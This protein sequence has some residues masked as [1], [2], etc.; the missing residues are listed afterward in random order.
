MKNNFLLLLIFGFLA[1]YI[2]IVLSPTV[3]A[4]SVANCDVCGYCPGEAA[5][6]NWEDCR[7]CVY[8]ETNSTI[9][10][11]ETTIRGANGIPTPHPDYYY[12]MVGCISTKPAEFTTFLINKLIVP[13]VGGIA[14]LYLLYGAGIVATSQ[15]EPEKLNYGKRIIYGAIIGL[16]FVLLSTFFIKF[17]TVD[18]FNLPEFGSQ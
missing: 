16:I 13:I 5:P 11:D 6:S 14:F 2:P 9:P 17:V 12:T 10:E 15:T 4:Q 18:V 8:P 1:F 3:I 7:Q